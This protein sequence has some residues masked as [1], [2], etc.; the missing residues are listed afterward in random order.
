MHF[1]PKCW[2]PACHAAVA[3][4]R[5]VKVWQIVVLPRR[6]PCL[7]SRPIKLINM[8]MIFFQNHWNAPMPSH[9]HQ[10][11]YHVTFVEAVRT[12]VSTPHWTF[13]YKVVRRQTP[14]MVSHISSTFSIWH[15]AL[16][17]SPHSTV[18]TTLSCTVQRLV[19]STVQCT[20]QCTV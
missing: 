9:L 12:K 20:V 18:Y 15:Q 13:I 16:Q 14:L 17:F 2:T 11:S 3:K 4:A 1:F 5:I 7:A 8:E 6:L 19:Q 10:R